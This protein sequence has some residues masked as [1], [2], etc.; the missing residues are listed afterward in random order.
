[1]GLAIKKEIAIKRL[2]KE[3]AIR[4]YDNK[5]NGGH[6]RTP[7]INVEDILAIV[8]QLDDVGKAKVDEALVDATNANETI[9]WRWGIKRLEEL[10]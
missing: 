10:G 7:V 8:Y 4:V 3:L 6:G 2:A 9:I 1:M 5:M